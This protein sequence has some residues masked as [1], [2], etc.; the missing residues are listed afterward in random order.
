MG[1]EGMVETPRKIIEVL[2]AH[3]HLFLLRLPTYTGQLQFSLV[4]RYNNVTRFYHQNK[5]IPDDR[6][7]SKVLDIPCSPEEH[8]IISTTL[9][10]VLVQNR[11]D[12]ENTPQYISWF[13]W[14][15][16]NHC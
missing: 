16:G 12:F 8:E 3:D 1:L 2:D 15:F 7:K 6:W 14:I 11:K 4:D 5:P 10:D 13:G 9:A